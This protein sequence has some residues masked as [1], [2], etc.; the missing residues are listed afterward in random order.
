M[1]TI[2]EKA[3]GAQGKNESVHYFK[4]TILSMDY[5]DNWLFSLP[6]MATL[7]GLDVMLAT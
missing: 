1:S 5:D 4:P 6:E 2:L 7:V 3:S